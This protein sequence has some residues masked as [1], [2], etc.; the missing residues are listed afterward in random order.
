MPLRRSFSLRE[1]K[2][3]SREVAR[4]PAIKEAPAR[5]SNDEAD[6]AFDVTHYFVDEVADPWRQKGETTW[7]L[8]HLWLD[9]IVK[10][11]TPIHS[12]LLVLKNA[13][14]QINIPNKL[15]QKTLISDQGSY[16]GER[17]IS[18][19]TGSFSGTPAPTPVKALLLSLTTLNIKEGKTTSV[20]YYPKA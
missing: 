11:C 3:A 12:F 8:E 2:K 1:P 4:F 19:V 18:S 17:G 15:C 5:L 16:S 10:S 14:C 7:A 20:N 9:H 13:T 6:A